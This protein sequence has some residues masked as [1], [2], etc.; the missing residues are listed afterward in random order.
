MHIQ[1]VK[2]TVASDDTYSS[3]HRKVPV[4]FPLN[5]NA[6][7]TQTLNGRRMNEVQ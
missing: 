3:G 1:K 7:I 6:I 4:P 2:Y 5:A